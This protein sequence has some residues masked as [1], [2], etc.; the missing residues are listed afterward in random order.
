MNNPVGYPGNQSERE[1]L[2]N[3]IGILFTECQRLKRQ[4]AQDQADI[5]ALRST[6]DILSE[7]AR[8]QFFEE[9]A[10]KES[11]TNPA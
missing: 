3:T 1:S 9:N 8:K 11:G 5:A 7:Q 10:K 6:N 4:Y 2:I